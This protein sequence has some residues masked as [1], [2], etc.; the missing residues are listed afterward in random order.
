MNTQTLQ[1]Y[2]DRP[3]WSYS[4]LNQ[5]LNICSLQ[6]CFEKIEKIPRPFTPVAI[7]MGSVYHR[8]MEFIALSRMEQKLPSETDTRDLFHE[9]WK[10]EGEDGPPLEKDDELSPE[11]CGR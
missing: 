3:H 4:S 6:W 5:L 8:V 9:L 10:R 11:E 2:R 7:A 1:S